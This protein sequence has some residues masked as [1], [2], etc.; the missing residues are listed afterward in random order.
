MKNVV[1]DCERN[2][3]EDIRIGGPHYLGYDFNVDDS[4][5]DEELKAFLQEK[6][7]Q[8]KRG[9]ISITIRKVE[10]PKIWTREEMED[11]IKNN[12]LY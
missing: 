9:C 3:W 8:Y 1:I 6:L 5:N 12:G 11:C 2:D 7:K 4:E 10:Q